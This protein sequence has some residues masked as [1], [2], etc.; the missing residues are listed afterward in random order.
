MRLDSNRI[1]ARAQWCSAPAGSVPA[2]GA[3]PQVARAV[4]VGATRPCTAR[5]GA[6][7]DHRTVRTRYP[8]PDGSAVEGGEVETTSGTAIFLP[9]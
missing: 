7:P 4:R 6:A 8:T 5:H 1:S 2:E 9:E 3:A